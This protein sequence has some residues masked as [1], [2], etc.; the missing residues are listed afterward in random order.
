MHNNEL[1]YQAIIEICK[2]SRAIMY[3]RV[4]EIGSQKANAEIEP[5]ESMWKEYSEQLTKPVAIRNAN[6]SGMLFNR[7]MFKNHDFI[8]CDFSNSLWVFSF[9][10]G[11]NFTGSNFFGMRTVLFPFKNTNCSYCN[12]SNANIYFFD[13]LSRNN[14]ENANFTNAEISSS[15]SFFRDEKLTSRARFYNAKMNGC[16]LIIRREPQPQ[17]NRT[18][19][20][21]KSLLTEIFSKD[22]LSAMYIDY[23]AKSSREVKPSRCLIATA[24]CGSN[25]DEVIILR[26]FRDTVLLTNF[27]GRLFI[28]TYNRTSPL[29]VL[30]IKSSP[31]VQYIVR[32]LIV[33]PIA[34]LVD[35]KNYK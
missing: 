5:Y 9:I 10:E 6:F 30:M 2:K 26:H 17:H 7:A 14:F 13:P 27:L 8:E 16:K 33:R 4:K 24:T 34:R 3:M 23:M 25:S 28:R 31:K 35:S 32:N 19:K 20:E 21:L 22:Q 1:Q 29:M 12:F 18:K 11:S 15:H